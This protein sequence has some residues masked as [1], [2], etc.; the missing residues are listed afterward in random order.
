MEKL[1]YFFSIFLLFGWCFG[2]S[3]AANQ[4]DYH[5]MTVEL[6]SLMKTEPGVQK[7]LEQSIERAKIANPDPKTNPIQS[8][9]QY[10]EFVSNTEKGMPW[11]LYEQKDSIEVYSD[12]SKSLRYFYF[13]INQP[14]PE[15]AGKGLYNNTIQFSE[16]FVSW[17]TKFNKEW[18]KYLSSEESWNDSYYQLAKADSLFG[19]N[20]SWYEAPSNWHSFNEFFARKL[21]SPEERPITFP[22]DN[23]IVTSFADSRPIGIWEIDSNSVLVAQE[24]VPVKSATFR[25][26]S[27]LIGEESEYSDAFKNGTFL[28]SFLAINDY[29][30]FHFPLN[31]VIIEVKLIPGLGV[32]GGLLEWDPANQR[33]AYDPTGIDW[34]ILETRGLV[35]LDTE[36]YG[37]VALIPVGMATIGSVNFED[38]VKE[39]ARVQKGD[40]LGYFQFGGSDFVMLFQES[41]QFTLDAPKM[42]HG[43]GYNHL[44]MGERLGSLSLKD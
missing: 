26:V 15:L 18:G 22:K 10:L 38:T 2:C 32:A 5:P 34:Q 23:Q 33:Y 7:L 39:G 35:I 14:L 41:V 27:K 16:P 31:G 3:D 25:S 20:S 4:V 40:P 6:I 37:L 19:L 28:H 36:D 9:E 42:D 17:L 29:H 12:I 44:L 30:R 24:G 43:A 21:R 1:H 13:L 8:L 11:S